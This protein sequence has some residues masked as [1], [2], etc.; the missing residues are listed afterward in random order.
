MKTL[1]YFSQ[2][3]CYYLT[4]TNRH[5]IHS[6][7]VFQLLTEVIQT[8][9]FYYNRSKKHSA[10][11]S[12][13]LSYFKPK[14][15]VEIGNYN[16]SE[17]SMIYY[18]DFQNIKGDLIDFIYIQKATTETLLKALKYMHNDSVL[19]LNNIH[20]TKEKWKF[21]QSHSKVNV[22]INLFY[23]GLIFLREQQEEQHFTIRF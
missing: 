19:V 15:I 12:R 2:Y 17:K 7:F 21:L 23:I 20:Q 13:L 1:I 22:S 16:L 5:G 4:A 11:T 9:R 10:L 18:K 14:S 6:P 8:K 3:I